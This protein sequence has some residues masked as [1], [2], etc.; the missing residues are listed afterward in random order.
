MRYQTIWFRAGKAYLPTIGQPPSG[1]FF[2]LDPVAVIDEPSVESLEHALGRAL[3]TPPVPVRERSPFASDWP[4]SVI[5]VRAGFKSWRSFAQAALNIS[6]GRTEE[7]WFITT[8]EG[9]SKEEVET[10]TLPKN[11]SLSQLAEA[12]MEVASRRTLWRL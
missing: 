1:L 2:E 11:S 7:V 6:L 4:D 8:F 9:P 5:Q 12:T 10:K 3:E